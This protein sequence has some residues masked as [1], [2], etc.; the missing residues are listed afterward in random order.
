MAVY[1]DGVTPS[2]QPRAG[3][4][5]S[6]G[7]AVVSLALM[8]GIGVWGYK[9][10]M[11]DVS[12]I[13]VVRAMEGEMRVA[14]ANPGGEVAL[15]TGLAV[16]EVAA[17]G[18]AGGPEDRLALAPRTQDLTE[19]DLDVQP[20]AEAG[21]VTATDAPVEE[22]IATSLNADDLL[23]PDQAPLEG[24]DILALA[25]SIAA[26]AQP[27]SDLAPGETVDPTVL[28]DGEQISTGVVETIAADVP[29]I[30]R[31]LRPSQRPLG[32]EVAAAAITG[33]TTTD[34]TTAPVLPQA[35]E[36]AVTTAIPPAGA[37]LVQLGAYASP[38]E[39]ATAWTRLEGTHATYLA[40]HE[41]VI[42]VAESAGQTFY[43][44][45]AAGFSGL[46]D[47]RRFCAA[48]GDSGVDCIPVMAR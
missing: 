33:G 11:R 41:R 27:L 9:L 16:N 6:Y 26:G 21:E 35:A 5:V 28:L 20:L 3:L 8:A 42:Q 38:D 30:A 34:V 12:G 2:A 24:T 18:E 47:A 4:W 23:E 13:P 10:V 37:T 48:L 31:S 46:D 1:T 45:R 32:L 7:G 39:A 22:A 36:I 17:V 14:P 40:G 43:R 29:G 19:E 44:L 25:D 15:N